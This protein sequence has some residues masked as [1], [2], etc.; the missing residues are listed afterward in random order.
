MGG[1]PVSPRR[2][3]GLY[4]RT[5]DIIQ[6]GAADPSLR[7]SGPHGLALP[8][9]GELGHK[10]A[11]GGKSKEFLRRIH[12]L[13]FPVLVLPNQQNTK[14]LRRFRVEIEFVV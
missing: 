12:G 8:A 2:G 9:A 4:R 5:L 7:H 13:A 10:L 1:H 6:F 11:F 14:A 3:A